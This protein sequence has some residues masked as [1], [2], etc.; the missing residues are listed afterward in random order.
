MSEAARQRVLAGR[1]EILGLLGRGGMAAVYHG[2]DRVLD[3][4]V[5]IKVLAGRLGGEERS[6]ARFRREARA[7]ASLS[8]PN[9]VA[10]YDAGVDAGEHFIVMELVDGP[11]L[12]ELLRERGPL[13]V[14]QAL[15]IADDVLNA[16]AAAHRAG[17]VH[18]DVSPGNVMVTRGG[19]AKV[20]DFGIARAFGP[21]AVAQTR[22]IAGTA[23]YLSPEQ[24]TGRAVTPASDLYSMGCV[25]YAML[26]GRPP[27]IGDLATTVAAQH[28]NATPPALSSLRDGLPPA[29]EAQVLRALAKRPKD[30]FASADEMRQALGRT[31]VDVPAGAA[32]AALIAA[33]TNPDSSASER[34]STRLV[35]GEPDTGASLTVALPARGDATTAS[36]PSATAVMHPSP[37]E[38]SRSTSGGRGARPGPGA[39]D[40]RRP[41]WLWALVAAVVAAGLIAVAAA[42]LDMTRN[43]SPAAPAGGVQATTTAEPSAVTPGP[44]TATPSPSATPS[45][46]GGAPSKA[47][48]HGKAKGKAKGKDK[49]GRALTLG[50]A[51]G[52]VPLSGAMRCRSAGAI[53]PLSRRTAYLVFDLSARVQAPRLPALLSPCGQTLSRAATTAGS[54]WL[55]AL[56]ES[57][58][59]ASSS[60]SRAR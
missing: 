9:V 2:R 25:L 26:S 5:A 30:R 60:L 32:R 24:A 51:A 37:V 29:L 39:P 44:A 11:S 48:G 52:E 6:L 7:A 50:C 23:A 13:T 3:R 1:Y 59:R 57:S 42:A 53:I 16:L 45:P 22:S 35:A 10:V 12:A 46:A 15:A 41:R 14:P 54:N 34:V 47:D 40:R 36:G 31:G 27:F 28:V 43:G 21:G 20:T 17:L 38:A 33:L 55:P 18:R 8:S 58:L 19:V 56:A 4:E 49:N